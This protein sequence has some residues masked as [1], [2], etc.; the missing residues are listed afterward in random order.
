MLSSAMACFHSLSYA[1][2]TIDNTTSSPQPMVTHTAKQC[3]LYVNLPIPHKT[4]VK[5]PKGFEGFDED[6]EGHKRM[7]R[8][9][10][11]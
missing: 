2:T 3:P 6:I 1:T 4:S 9:P 5:I 10:R 8:P 7:P 11:V